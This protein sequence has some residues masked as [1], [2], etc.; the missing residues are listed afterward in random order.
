MPTAVR[1]EFQHQGHRLVYDV[2]G[3]GQ[4]PFV[5]L[6]GL[7]LP[8]TMHGPLAELLAERGNRV[9]C[10]DLLGHGESDRPRDMTRYSM[11][12][13]AEQAI[14]L[15]DHL[16]LDEAVVGGTSL[17][18]NVTL[19]AAVQAPERIRGIVVEMP[20]LDNALVACAL[21]F[22]PLLVYLTLGEPLARVVSATVG[23]LPRGVWHWADVGL[24]WIGQDPRPSGAVL[25]GLFF[26]RIAPPSS[27]RRAFETRAL[28]FGHPR[29]PIHPFNDADTRVRELPN[30]RLVEAT[31][32]IEFR[33]TPDRLPNEL[34]RFLDECWRPAEARS[35]TRQPRRRNRG[36]SA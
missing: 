1:G 15:L 6:P 11:P 20:V 25:Q 31:S 32:M 27:E 8:R 5:L 12:L 14:A 23:R 7:L 28:V 36:A 16:E 17:G 13:F 33:L 10:L 29:D 30:G 9:I 19:E 18:A 4:R 26:G 24:D 2:Y 22:S 3:E 35:P 34:A 21:A